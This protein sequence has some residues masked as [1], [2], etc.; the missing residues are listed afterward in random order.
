MMS[1]NLV[2]CP[3]QTHQEI[4][5]HPDAGQQGQG[6]AQRSSASLPDSE[7]RLKT[8]NSLKPDRGSL[9]SPDHADAAM[10]HWI[11]SQPHCRWYFLTVVYAGDRFQGPKAEPYLQ[12]FDDHVCYKLR[13]LIGFSHL[14]AFFCREYEYACTGDHRNLHHVHAVVGVGLDSRWDRLEKNY[15]AAL[16][17]KGDISSVNLQLIA[18]PSD[19]RNCYGYLRKWKWHQQPFTGVLG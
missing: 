6:E 18:G 15:A 3:T 10:L 5:K 11:Q 17:A 8:W 19:I 9:S 14:W 7:R 2:S 13:R 4:R 16:L 12:H 1:A